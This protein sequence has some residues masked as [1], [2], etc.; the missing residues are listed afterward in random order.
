MSRRYV[1][2][3]I[4]IISRKNAARQAVTDDPTAP[5]QVYNERII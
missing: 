2:L 3:Y 5:K 4:F 1:V